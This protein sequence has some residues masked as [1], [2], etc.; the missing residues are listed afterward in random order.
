MSPGMYHNNRRRNH[1]IRMAMNE[2]VDGRP[3]SSRLPRQSPFVEMPRHHTTHNNTVS[4]HTHRQQY[5]VNGLA[6]C[7]HYHIVGTDLSQQKY[8]SD[9]TFCRTTTFRNVRTSSQHDTSRHACVSTMVL[10]CRHAVT[11]CVVNIRAK[12][13]YGSQEAVVATHTIHR[14][15]PGTAMLRHTIQDNIHKYLGRPT[16]IDVRSHACRG[17]T[18]E[19]RQCLTPRHVITSTGFVT[20]AAIGQPRRPLRHYEDEI[21]RAATWRHRQY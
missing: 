19:G 20:T 6:Q 9:N 18:A 5:R 3:E 15:Q 11:Q 17:H 4:H 14:Q 7:Y 8:T 21:R 2:I 16:L 12:I 1:G 10:W 13:Q